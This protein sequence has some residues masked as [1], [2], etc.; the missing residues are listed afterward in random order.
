M[1]VWPLD[2]QH[3]SKEIQ[4][5]IK[6]PT[7]TAEES[8]YLKKHFLLSREQLLE[9]IRKAGRTPHVEGGG[10]LQTYVLPNE[11][12][13]P[14]LFVVQE[15]VDYSRYDRFHINIADNGTPVDEF[16]QFLFGSGYVV[17][18]RLPDGKIL[19]LHLACSEGIGWILTY[20][21]GLPHIG[22]V[23]KATV[24]TKILVQVI[25]PEKWTM[26]YDD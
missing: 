23:S 21:G 20:S 15:G 5:L 25:G 6:Q 11:H 3:E 22:S 19:T 14:Q 18:Q 9:I 16:A 26:R 24:G 7:L 10:E 13:F 1:A 12:S 2:L 17:Y 8:E 4:N